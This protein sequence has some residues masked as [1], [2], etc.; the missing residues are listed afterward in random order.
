MQIKSFRWALSVGAVVSIVLWFLTFPPI[1]QAGAEA[2]ANPKGL[3]APGWELK[4]LDGKTVK[5]SDFEGKVIILDFWATWC[6]PCKKEI[7]GFVELQKKYGRDG[8][9]I[10]GVSL[11]EGGPQAVKPF[12]KK[13]G[14]SYPVVMGNGGITSDYG[15]IEAIP[16]TF[17][18]NRK[19][20]IV[21]KHLGFEEEHVFETEIKSLLKE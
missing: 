12:L 16:T 11:D 6:G 3:R 1:L 17:I 19:G 13:L 18:I 4:D 9:A 2:E 21:H 8:L 20:M 10:I 5:L 7:P 14:V 15:G